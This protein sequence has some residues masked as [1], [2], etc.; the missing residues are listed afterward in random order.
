MRERR[1]ELTN[2]PNDTKCIIWARFCGSADCLL[3]SKNPLT[4]MKKVYDR[5]QPHRLV[6]VARVGSV[7]CICMLLCHKVRNNPTDLRL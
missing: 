1:K 5:K 7:S 4:H 2:G 3:L 6:F